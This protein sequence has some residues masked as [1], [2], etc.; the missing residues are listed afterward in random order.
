MSTAV[1]PYIE[2]AQAIAEAGGGIFKNAINVAHARGR[3]PGVRSRILISV[4]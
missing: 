3:V 2:M 1:T 4:S